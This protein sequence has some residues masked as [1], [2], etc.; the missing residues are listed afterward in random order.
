MFS[1]KDEAY[2]KLKCFVAA[3]LTASAFGMSFNTTE[4]YESHIG[5]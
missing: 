1:K 3:F 4:P 2:S 5:R